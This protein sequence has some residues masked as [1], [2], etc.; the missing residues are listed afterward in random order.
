MF[1]FSLLLFRFTC[2]LHS[3][4]S[5]ALVAVPLGLIASHL[6]GA[7]LP[8]HLDT[9]DGTMGLVTLLRL[10]RHGRKTYRYLTEAL[11]IFLFCHVLAS[12]K[13]SFRTPCVDEGS[14]NSE[15]ERCGWDGAKDAD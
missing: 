14:K 11:L 10:G 13:L 9:R 12:P 1:F 2:G 5:K 8:N 6:C 7:L 3:L 15:R 4:V